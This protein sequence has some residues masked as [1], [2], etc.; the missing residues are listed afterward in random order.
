MSLSFCFVIIISSSYGFSRRAIIDAAAVQSAH[1]GFAPRVGGLAIYLSI[2]GFIPLSTFGFVPLSVVFEIGIKEI[3]WLILSALPVFT[4]GFF[5]DLGYP[6]SPK[7]RLLSSVVSSS[8]V[9]ILLEIWISKL[10]IIGLDYFLNLA[11]FGIIFTLFATAGVVNA[12]NLIDG[13][14][15]LSGYVTISTSLAISVIAFQTKNTEIMFFLLLIF[16]ATC[17]FLVLNFPFGKIFLG[18][19][20]AYLLG[21]LLVWS[22]IFLVN[23]EPDVSPFAILLIFFWPVA[24]TIWAILRRLKLGIRTDRPDRL[25]F[26]Q[27]IMRLL[28]IRLLGRKKRHIA[29]PFATI[30]LIPFIS[31][32]QLLGVVLWDQY[33]ATVWWRFLWVCYSY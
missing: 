26:H 20:G 19:A 4:V 8:L 3:S 10:G 31:I 21:H 12:F 11:P 27:L 13:L 17:G 16:A 28:E 22:S 5:E 33:E 15:G 25:H 24:D 14:N 23:Q 18:D 9:L 32:P 6:M 30:I 29:N 1:Q 2:L 7:V